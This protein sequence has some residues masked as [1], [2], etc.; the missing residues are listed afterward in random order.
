MGKERNLVW[1]AIELVLH[2][3][4][5]E[6]ILPETLFMNVHYPGSDK[7][8][9]EVYPL[10]SAAYKVFEKG[11]ILPDSFGYPVKP[12]I[13]DDNGITV[14]H[15]DEIGYFDNPRTDDE[16]EMFTSKQMNIILQDFDG[17][18]ELL[19]Y[20]DELEDNFIQP[21]YIGDDSLVVIRGLTPNEDDD[22]AD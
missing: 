4:Y 1:I 21:V 18:C 2:H 17:I 11:M 7:E 5:D 9:V 16:Y 14:V 19:V 22:E 12:H 3:D 8:F 6:K 15:P 10:G 13:I 20:E